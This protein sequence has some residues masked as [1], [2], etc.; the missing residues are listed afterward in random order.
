M[1]DIVE[2]YM[3]KLEWGFF[4]FWIKKNKLSLLLALLILI[5]WA[6]SL[7][8]I[9]KESSPEI[10]FGIISVM[11]TYEW[12]S[13]S[14]VDD[15]ITQEIETEIENIEWIKK[16]N[17]TSSVWMSSVIVELKNSADVSEVKNKIS[18]EVDKIS[19]PSDVDDPLIQKI[20]SDTKLMFKLILYGNNKDFWKNYLLKK[21]KYIQSKIESLPW[22]SSVDI[23]SATPQFEWIGNSN[24]SEFEI[25]IIVDKD[26]LENIGIGLRDVTIAIREYNK[27]QPLW[28]YQIWKL[29]YD[30][31]IQWELENINQIKNIPIKYDDDGS[32]VRL[33]DVSDIQKIS[34][35]ER[36]LYWWTYKKPWNVYVAMDV[37]KT[38]KSDIFSVSSTVKDFVKKEFKTEWFKNLG[39]VYTYDLS[40][41]LIDDYQSLGKSWILT[42]VLVFWILFLF[43]WFKES[44][45]ATLSLPLAFSIT[46]FVLNFMGYTLNFLTNFSLIL[47]LWVAIDTIIVI[48][49]WAHEK[50]R[51]WYNSKASILLSVKDFWPPLIAGTTTT[52]M[53]FLPMMFL[54]GVMWKFLAYIPITVFVTLVAALFLALTINS[55]IFF[56]LNKA[57]KTYEKQEWE[58][59]FLSEEDKE[60]LAYHRKWKIQKDFSNNGRWVREKVF[61]KI[62]NIYEDFLKKY[63]SKKIY[64]LSG[65][66]IPVLALILTIFFLSP[67]IWF[68]L[69]PSGDNPWIEVSVSW[70]PS[71]VKEE[72][73]EN[74][75]IVDQKISQTP[76]VKWY[77]VE[78]NWN[79]VDGFIELYSKNYRENNNMRYSDKV[80]DDLS[81][82][83]SILEKKWLKV[84]ISVLEDWPPSSAPIW[85]KLIA[86]DNSNFESLQEVSKDFEKY[87]K[88]LTWAK[89]VTNSVQSE[90]WQFVFSLKKDKIKSLG[91]NLDTIRSKIYTSLNWLGA[92]SLKAWEDA[93]IF[94]KYDQFE[95]GAT[96][97]EINELKIKTSQW[98]INIWSI[99]DYKITDAIN[100]ISRIDTD[101][102]V[103][104]NSELESWYQPLG[105]QWKLIDYAKGYNF[106]EGVT[107][108]KSW[109]NIE[110]QDLI[111]SVIFSFFIALFLIFAILVLQFN[112]YWKPFIILYSVL[113]AMLWVN[114]WLYFT[115]N[116]YSIPFGIWFI[117]LTGI[118]VNDAIILID[119]I[120]KNFEKWMNWI[121]AI[122]KAWRTRLQPIILT[123]LTTIFWI[124][125]LAF[126]D[127][128][129][130]GISFT[131]V[132]GLFAGSFMT[133]FA[134]PSLYYEI[135]VKE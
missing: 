135:F 6:Y 9:P 127:P 133:L 43:I 116:P 68:E 56:K 100:A 35:D 119:R 98:Y 27:N 97:N 59:D 51:M 71:L 1:S 8:D 88:T 64:R 75:Q 120:N 11:T 124:W 123:T 79:K 60:V 99:V 90:K 81:D 129:W 55:A 112:S 92:G 73:K 132:F 4:W 83:F 62:C 103:Q 122:T 22:I 70:R 26:K 105:V 21:G 125:P 117:A 104:I 23:G 25:E 57:K 61:D 42:L 2:K 16:I 37:N 108:K 19:F 76:E 14:D 18:D 82:S 131:I 78:V 89:N 85:I 54:P 46:F 72:M 30:F 36:I 91:L 44:L 101:I 58:D 106:P 50:M 118:V 94:V 67:K 115:G 84:D 33:W 32:V 52:V 121:L 29:K 53:A 66:L 41:Y 77:T 80:W 113:L 24:D 28:E 130:A 31:R 3:T 93:D 63:L 34:D 48:I 74:A 39:Y 109:E 102:T 38:K 10:D 107:Y 126:K 87:L 47:T 128:F 7:Y 12:A 95:D 40:E 13:P 15:I 20:S 111:K 49:E 5:L 114:I 96:P 86:Q 110:N 69:F 65:F 45:V 134:L 17:S